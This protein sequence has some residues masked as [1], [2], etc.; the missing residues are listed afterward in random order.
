[1]AA[2]TFRFH[3]TDG[4][5]AIIDTA[6]VDVPTEAQLGRYAEQ[7][8][9]YAMAYVGRGLD[10]SE[11]IVDVHDPNGRRVLMLPFRDVRDTPLAA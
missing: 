5:V 8:A 9:R 10:W 11:W 6:G 7:A 2:R 3:C 4:Q 1:M